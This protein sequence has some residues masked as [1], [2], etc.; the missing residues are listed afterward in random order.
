MPE[1]KIS[2]SL[3]SLKQEILQYII[4]KD[5]SLNISLY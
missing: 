1:G 3:D 2:D 5:M 4:T